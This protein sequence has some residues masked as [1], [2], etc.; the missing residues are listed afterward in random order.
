VVFFNS[1][2][3]YFKD[4]GLWTDGRGQDAVFQL[5]GSPSV[6]MQDHGVFWEPETGYDG[7]NNLLT[8][9]QQNTQ[10]AG[11]ESVLKELGSSLSQLYTESKWNRKGF[12]TKLNVVFALKETHRILKEI[13][14]QRGPKTQHSHTP[15]N[16]RKIQEITENIE[17]VLVVQKNWPESLL[18][19]E[20]TRK[21][22]L[23]RYQ[24][25]PLDILFKEGLSGRSYDEVMGK[26]LLFEKEIPY[27]TSK[28][29]LKE[30]QD[31]FSDFYQPSAWKKLDFVEK[32]LVGYFFS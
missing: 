12:E 31:L 7:L 14:Q 25:T 20:I 11:V 24:A 26:A 18:T 29:T 1:R 5:T 22:L 23:D 19:S 8:Y 32:L 2:K 21:E 9:L 28:E 15:A 27:I 30:L 16:L 3:K 6:T 13:R 17:T 4:N 10:A